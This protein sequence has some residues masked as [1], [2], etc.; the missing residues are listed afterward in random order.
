[1]PGTAVTILTIVGAEKA[2]PGVAVRGEATRTISGRRERVKFTQPT[3]RHLRRSLAVAAVSIVPIVLLAVPA[4][5][6]VVPPVVAGTIVS[7]D[8]VD[9]TPHARDGEVRAFAQI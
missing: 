9:N 7:A 2:I 1:M 4:T 3:I 5:A 6:V 8:P